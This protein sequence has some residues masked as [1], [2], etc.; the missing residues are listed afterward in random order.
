MKV[1][2]IADD[3]KEFSSETECLDYEW[4]LKH[5]HL[6]EIHLYDEG[7]NK[8]VNIFSEDVYGRTMKVVVQ[9]QEA[10]KDLQ[11]LAQYTGFSCY[12]DITECGVWTF[13]ESKETFVKLEYDKLISFTNFLKILEHVKQESCKMIKLCADYVMII[14]AS[15]ETCCGFKT[16]KDLDK[17]REWLMQNVIS[18]GG[19]SS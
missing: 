4:K 5:S 8:L 3:G 10:L 15:S 9:T 17:Y 18:G 11:E 19:A 2:Y 14:E 16:D 12:Y 6:D 13:N 1:I 7:N